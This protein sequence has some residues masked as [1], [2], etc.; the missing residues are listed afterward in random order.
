MAEVV[1]T[2]T[3]DMMYALFGVHAVTD[4]D[5]DFIQ[6]ALGIDLAGVGA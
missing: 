1:S 5:L 3:D 2:E 6:N 4:E